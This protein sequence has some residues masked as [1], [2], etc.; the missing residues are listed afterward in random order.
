[1]MTEKQKLQVLRTIDKLDRLGPEA[2][3]A[4]LTDGRRDESGAWI[5][6]CGL[7]QTQAE[8]ILHFINIRGATNEETLA[9]MARFFIIMF[10]PEQQLDELHDLLEKIGLT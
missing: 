5:D 8:L 1:M 4:L 2:I 10:M 6:G 7:S 9:L 3:M